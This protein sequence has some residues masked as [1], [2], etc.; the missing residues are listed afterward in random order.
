MSP[1]TRHLFNAADDQL[2]AYLNEEG[3]TIEPEWCVCVCVCV[4]GG[5]WQTCTTS[6]LPNMTYGQT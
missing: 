3:Q 1:I 2:L 4:A 6:V 5:W